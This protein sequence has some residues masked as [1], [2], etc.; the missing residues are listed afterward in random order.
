MK[1]NQKPGYLVIG[2][3]VIGIVS[4]LIIYVVLIATGLIQV[5]KNHIVITTA[6]AEKVYDGAELTADWWE[7]AY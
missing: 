6:S 7:L 4:I 2:S 1:K 5:S 3:V